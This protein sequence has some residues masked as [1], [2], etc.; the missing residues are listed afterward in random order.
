MQMSH[1]QNVT[2]FL[3]GAR[4]WRSGASF[5]AKPS[6]TTSQ[7]RR[8]ARHTCEAGSGAPFLHD[9]AGPLLA[10]LVDVHLLIVGHG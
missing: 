5:A 10:V 7:K 2:A 6:R 9:E 4:D 1:D 3:C 8:D